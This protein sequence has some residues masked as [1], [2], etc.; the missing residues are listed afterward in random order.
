[1]Y[2]ALD[3]A[4]TVVIL[5]E[6]L[7]GIANAEE[8]A[9]LDGVD[10]LAIGANDLTAELGAAGQFHHPAVRDAIATVATACRR[11]GKLL[12]VGG[13]ADLTVLDPL[14]SLGVCPLQ[15]TGMDTELLL[16][17]ARGRAATYTAW[18]GAHESARVGAL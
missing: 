6:T 7:A 13:I 2:H 10:V 11:H 3:D 12:Q 5:L 15:L 16:S 1:M 4:T 9:K 18:N 17:G 8:I 14:M